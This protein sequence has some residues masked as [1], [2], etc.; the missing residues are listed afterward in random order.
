MLVL[1]LRPA[2]E[3]R[4]EVTHEGET[5]VLMVTYSATN[6]RAEVVIDAPKSF[7]IERKKGR[8]KP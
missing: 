2:H 5:M 7:G 4:L 3:E 1:T 6:H 8:A